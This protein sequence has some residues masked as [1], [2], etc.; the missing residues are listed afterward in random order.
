MTFT[1]FIDKLLSYTND[2]RMYFMSWWPHDHLTNC[3]CMVMD[4]FCDSEAL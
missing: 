2:V 4:T 1:I 3:Q